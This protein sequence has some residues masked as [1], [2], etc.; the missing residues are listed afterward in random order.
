MI[1]FESIY[2]F[3]IRLDNGKII[4]LTQSEAEQLRD[5]LNRFV[6]RGPPKS[7]V[8]GNDANTEKGYKNNEEQ[9]KLEF[10]LV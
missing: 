8:S 2:Q 4:V 6:P 5:Y 7:S 3:R 9:S 1:E 10:K